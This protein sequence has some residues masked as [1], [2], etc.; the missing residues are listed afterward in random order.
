MV[1]KKGDLVLHNELHHYTRD[2]NTELVL[3]PLYFNQ[4]SY[5]HKNPP[6]SVGPSAEQYRI[7]LMPVKTIISP[8]ILFMSIFVINM[9]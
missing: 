8:E 2:M 6:L 5:D 4:N 7:Y 1:E 3:R 9:T